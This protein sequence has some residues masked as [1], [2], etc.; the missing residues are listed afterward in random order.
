MTMYMS[1][2]IGEEYDAVISGVTSF[3]LFAELP[4]TVEGFIPME[5]LYG[6]Y[7]F[8][9]ERFC[10]IGE[11]GSYTIG[12]EIRIKVIDVDFYRRRTEF[13]LLSKKQGTMYALNENLE[14]WYENYYNE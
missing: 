6:T 1:D 7:K 3:G 11:R 8:D 9:A 2:H 12:E 10:I 5:S 4:N 14:N 13:R